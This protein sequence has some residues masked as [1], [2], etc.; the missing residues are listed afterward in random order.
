V[1]NNEVLG[2]KGPLKPSPKRLA[3]FTKERGGIYRLIFRISTL[4]DQLSAFERTGCV[5]SHWVRSIALVHEF[6]HL[7]GTSVFERKNVRL[8]ALPLEL[9]LTYDTKL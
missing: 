3:S 8:S 7:I 5:R 2:H 6:W 4:P 1:K 9:A